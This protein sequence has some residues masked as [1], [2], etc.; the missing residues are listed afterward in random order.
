MTNTENFMAALDNKN[1]L[2]I[3][4]VIPY[5]KNEE[6]YDID[7]HDEEDPLPSRI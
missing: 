5:P 7:G 1:D 6:L 2:W 4:G 3:W